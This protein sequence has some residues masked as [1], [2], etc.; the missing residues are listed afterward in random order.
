MNMVQM[1]GRNVMKCDGGAGQQEAG[2]RKPGCGGRG[3]ERTGAGHTRAY[4]H[5]YY[6]PPTLRCIY[7][8][9]I[10]GYRKHIM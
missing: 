1:G 5:M 10:T 3:E 7:L 2:R 8:N 6:S 9:N 4:S